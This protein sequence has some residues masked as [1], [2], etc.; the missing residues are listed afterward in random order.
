MG[1]KKKSNKS[2]VKKE[3]TVSILTC[4]QLK[5]I[6]FI[7][8]LSIMI[9][10]QT[11]NNI[12]EWVI[13]NGCNND[14]DFDKF[15]EDIKRI[16]TDKC[17]VIIA[18]DKNLNY[19]NIGAFRNLGNRTVT[20]DIVVCMDDDDFYFPTY[21]KTCVDILDRN[22]NYNLVGCSGMLM[23][24]YGFDTVF[25][26]RPFGP[27]HTVN[28]CMAYRL[29]YG[30]NNLYEENRTT[31]EEKSFLRDYQSPLFQIPD[32]KN[33]IIHM[34]YADNTY[35]EKRL[36][37][38]NNM[39]A[40]V[41]NPNVPQIYNETNYKLKDLINNETILSNYMK[42]FQRINNQRTTDVVFYYGNIEKVWDPRKKN[43]RVVYRRSIELA[44][45]FIKRGLTVSIYGRFDFNELIED[46]IVFYNLKYFNV[47]RKT[48]NLIFM[49]YIGFI[50]LGQYER[51]YK[52]INA[53]NIY[54]D[55]QCNLFQ[56]KK[57][58]RNFHDNLT[59]V[60]KNP[61]HKLMNPEQ[62]TLELPDSDKTVKD[63]VV[64][65]GI[66][67]DTFCKNYNVKRDPYRFCYTSNYVNG[68]EPLIKYCWPKILEKFPDAQFHIYYGIEE[69]KINGDGI[70]MLKELFIQ[71]GIYEHGRVTYEEIAIEMQK[72]SFLLYY[73][74][75][76]AEC[77]CVSVMEALAS[78]CIPVIWDQNLFNKFNGLHV[79]NDPR[80]KESYE[81]LAEKL[82]QLMTFDNDR[83]TVIEKFKNS[84]SIIDW[85]V[86][87]DMYSNYFGGVDHEKIIKE[88]ELEM[89]R[90]KE[91]NKFKEEE[92]KRMKEIRDRKQKYNLPEYIVLNSYVD[93]DT[94]EDNKKVS[95]SVDV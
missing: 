60:F 19:R 73:T 61:Y 11:F 15:N 59:L 92:L 23:Y 8:G 49:D 85:G 12:K 7:E 20:G 89:L 35:S 62:T 81:I 22:K 3:N 29:S 40:N 53:E 70:D 45:E 33:A 72:S 51:I 37:Q 1:N 56:I 32:N 25:N 10:N 21:V 24:D 76:P 14:E 79:S 44:K 87:A 83:K 48:K 78:G 46:E 30:K 13:V 63:I 71:D 80:I 42:N 5:R 67:K 39:A 75:S 84:S 27:N 52:K 77:D 4:S 18:S 54:L 88:R 66:I 16:K 17:E 26:L 28:C 95:F 47:R 90:L 58:L 38:M 93:S 34:S 41:E 36:N 91:Y 74:S 43:L 57:Y 64:P 50:P 31:G 6:D 69:T 9:N 82:I 68:I 2:P 86:S 94:E 65:N 55:I